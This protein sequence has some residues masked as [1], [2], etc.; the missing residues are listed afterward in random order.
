MD[1]STAKTATSTHVSSHKKARFGI[2]SSNLEE[3]KCIVCAKAMGQ[4][5][6]MRKRDDLKRISNNIHNP[7]EIL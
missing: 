7:V 5:F 2:D 4:V 6:D 3:Q 1:V